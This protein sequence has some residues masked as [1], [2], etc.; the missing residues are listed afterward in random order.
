[1]STALIFSGRVLLAYHATRPHRH[2]A[3][4]TS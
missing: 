4:V 1:M 3:K 2:E